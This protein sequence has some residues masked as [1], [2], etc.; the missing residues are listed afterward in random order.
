LE[1]VSLS[2]ADK[3]KLFYANARRILGLKDPTPA[4]TAKKEPAL[5]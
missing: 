3:H 4:K 5:V 1:N 2:E